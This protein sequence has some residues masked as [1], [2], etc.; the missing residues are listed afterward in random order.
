MLPTPTSP[1]I[2]AGVAAGSTKISAASPGTADLLAFPNAIG[3]DGTDIGAVEEPRDT[4]GDGIADVSDNAPPHPTR[5][6]RTQ[7]A[8]ARVTP[9]TQMTTAMALPTRPTTA[10]E[11]PTPASRTSTP[12]AQAT[13]ATRAMTA[14][15]LTGGG[16]GGGGGGVPPPTAP[17]RRSSAAPGS[18]P[19]APSSRQPTARS[20]RRPASSPRGQARTPHQ[21]EGQSGNSARRRVFRR[22]GAEQ[23]SETGLKAPARCR[24]SKKMELGGLEPPTS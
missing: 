9:A 7:T 13:P 23:G 16:G 6:R 3:G 18:V 4:E 14:P 11:L 12:T 21:A 19:C 8:M 20:A 10:R 5:R 22:C 17:C 2:D 1:A 15:R 24:A